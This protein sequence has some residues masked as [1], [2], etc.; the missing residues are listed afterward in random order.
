MY[1]RLTLAFAL[2]ACAA[3]AAACSSGTSVPSSGGVQGVGP[4]FPTNSIYVSNT[5]QDAVEI[6]APSPGPSATPQYTIGGSLSSLNGPAYLAFDPNKRLYVTNYNGSTG[7]A[8]IEVYQ[9]YATGN[10]LPYASIGLAAGSQPRGIAAIPTGGMLVALNVPGALYGSQLLV[11]SAASLTT[12][13]A[14]EVIE[15]PGTGLSG[16]AGIAI[17]SSGNAYVANSGNATVTAYV[18]PTPTPSPSGSPTPTPSPTA[19]PTSTPT[20]SPLPSGVT[21]TPAPTATPYSNVIPPFLTL[22]N[23]LTRPVGVALDAKGDLYVADAGTAGGPGPKIV[24][25]DAPLANAEAATSTIAL[26][27]GANPS[28]IKVDANGTVYVLNSAAGGGSQLLVYAAGATTPS[29]TLALPPGTATGIA[30]SP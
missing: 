11:Y 4:N 20:P 28:D 25:F 16:P 7:A 26:P 19:T 18:V 15:G 3:V 5:T 1:R 2:L 9:T 30:L 22:S 8:A 14:Q 24:I 23:D 17:D 29:E 10:V 6:L 27:A 12:G 13:F 21:P